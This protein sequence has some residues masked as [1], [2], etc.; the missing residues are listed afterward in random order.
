MPRA[1]QVFKTL[2]SPVRGREASAKDKMPD[3]S[4]GD[5]PRSQGPAKPVNP[6]LPSVRPR[7]LFSGDNDNEENNSGGPKLKS[8]NKYFKSGGLAEVAYEAKKTFLNN[9][10]KPD[11]RVFNRSTKW[12]QNQQNKPKNED[13]WLGKPSSE[14][15]PFQ[16]KSNFYSPPQKTYAS[17]TRQ[18]LSERDLNT[19]SSTNDNKPSQDPN[20]KIECVTIDEAEEDDKPLLGAVSPAKSL[21]EKC[22]PHKVGLQNKG[23]TCY[24]N[25]TV[26]ALLGLPMVV[27]DANNLKHALIKRQLS[28]EDTKLVLPFTSLCWSQSQGDVTMTNNKAVEVKQ[29]M[30][31]LDSQFAGHRM[32]DANEFLCR[33]MDELKENIG[34]MFD[35]A[36]DNK[37]LEVEDDSGS[38]HTLTNLVDT[39][40]QYEKRETF[41]CTGC[42]HQSHTKY[43]DVNFF[44]DLSGMSN[45][46]WT[47]YTNG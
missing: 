10:L 20:K 46:D 44:L 14:T 40:F 1:A 12:K 29:D 4:A 30:E 22:E 6:S 24:L 3:S 26:Q 37:E 13:G 7:S 38:R 18:G 33:F 39:N 5:S 17:A 43:T 19:E 25:S 45:H 28:T 16:F 9:K 11:T 27:T 32:Q 8:T 41:V 36:G 21:P 47:M 34:K 15:S 23:N 42:G 2:H 35:V 31:Q